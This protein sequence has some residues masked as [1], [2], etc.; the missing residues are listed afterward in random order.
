M[1]DPVP[2]FTPTLGPFR[3][4]TPPVT[5]ICPAVV[6]LKSIAPPVAV[7]LFDRATA[8]ALLLPLPCM[9]TFPT[10]LEPVVIGALTFNVAVVID[11]AG[12]LVEMELPCT[13]FDIVVW[14]PVAAVDID[15]S[16]PADMPPQVDMFP[17]LVSAVVSVFVR[18]IAPAELI[19]PTCRLP[20]A[21]CNVNE[22]PPFGLP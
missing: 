3:V 14:A 16:P 10:L 5:C 21:T 4:P 19:A 20:L 12:V 1:V 11:T 17:L 6:G 9:F 2:P 7:M 13:A 22:L 15:S 8:S 18:L